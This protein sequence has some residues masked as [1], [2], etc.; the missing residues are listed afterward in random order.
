MSY[1]RQVGAHEAFEPIPLAPIEPTV[2]TDTPPTA[3]P[4]AP[5]ARAEATA[6]SSTSSPAA[7]LA[8]APPPRKAGGNFH[9]MPVVGHPPAFYEKHIRQAQAD[10]DLHALAAH[11]VGQ[12]VTAGLDPKL[13]WAEK[14]KRFCHCLEKY[15]VPP[16]DA[17]DA[18]QAFY[19][20][21]ADLVR[22]HAGQEALQSARQHH[23]EYLRR[24]KG[25]EPR[26]QIEEDAE[27]YFFDLL[28]HAQCPNWCSKEAWNQITEWR[29][30]WV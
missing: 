6:R 26:S 13:P 15:C 29:D 7:R 17:D 18:L 27:V 3:A 24:L 19:Q 23:Q 25:G 14:L 2:L 1:V 16:E 12:Y 30:F 4:P 28:G 11:K 22:R 10:G 8:T 21:M 20:K 9:P 5:A